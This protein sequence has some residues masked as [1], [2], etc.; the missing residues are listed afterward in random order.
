M[1]LALHRWPGPLPGWGEGVVVIGIATPAGA[2]RAEARV[3]IRQAA[4]E[5]LAQ[6]LA[7]PPAHITVASTPGSAPRVLVGGAPAETGLSISHA[8]GMSLAALRRDGPIGIDLMEVEEVLDWARVALDYLGMANACR[9]AS[10]APGERPLA[11][12]QAWTAREASL[13]LLGLPLSEWQ[14]LPADCRVTA[15]ALPPGLT[16]SL[17]M[18]AHMQSENK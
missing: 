9:L 5:A 1:A 7:V 18:P 4:R 3:A 14:P 6:L 8:G 16:G 11:F 12:A 2:S 15:L 10:L 17:A 13:K